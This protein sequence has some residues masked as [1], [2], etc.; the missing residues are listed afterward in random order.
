[1]SECASCTHVARR[2]VDRIDGN[3]HVGCALRRMRHRV[4]IEAGSA[5]GLSDLATV[6]TGT[7]ATVFTTAG[8][9][10]GTTTFACGP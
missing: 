9:G 7:S 10:A 5:P 8:V 2:N 6:N 1:M 4:L 3:A